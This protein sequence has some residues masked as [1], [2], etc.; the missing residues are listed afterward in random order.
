MPIWAKSELLGVLGHVVV[1]MLAASR[2]Y[3]HACRLAVKL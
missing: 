1:I 3:E 2:S